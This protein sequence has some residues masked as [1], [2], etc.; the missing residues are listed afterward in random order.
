MSEVLTDTTLETEHFLRRGADIGCLG[1]EAKI[2]VDPPRQIKQRLCQRAIRQER[3][4]SIA[5]ELCVWPHPRRFE[6]ELIGIEAFPTE[7]AGQTSHH[8]FPSWRPF[9]PSHRLVVHR[10][11][12]AGFYLQ[13]V[14]PFPNRKVSD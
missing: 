6:N 5:C 11:F 3:F 1:I 14:M 2:P 10:H 7:I 13:F 4:R 9:G 8:F 12:A